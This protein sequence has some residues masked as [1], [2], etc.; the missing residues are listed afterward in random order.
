M[1]KEVAVI[2]RNSKSVPSSEPGGSGSSVV[3]GEGRIAGLLM[4]GA[5]ATDSSDYIYVTPIFPVDINETQTVAHLKETIKAKTQSPFNAHALHLY[6][7]NITGSSEQACIEEANRRAQNLAA[8]QKL[9]SS[10]LLSNVFVRSG[11]AVD[12]SIPRKLNPFAALIDF[13][14]PQIPPDPL[15]HILVQS[16]KSSKWYICVSIPLVDAVVS[17]IENANDRHLP[18]SIS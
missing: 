9:D 2:L 11:R 4:G 13:F 15:I 10:A 8:L 7:V 14:V 12:L 17:L 18:W 16:P 5:G 1:S 3:D 6:L